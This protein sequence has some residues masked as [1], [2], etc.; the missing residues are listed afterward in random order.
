[1][2]RSCCHVANLLAFLVCLS[3]MEWLVRERDKRGTRPSRD[4]RAPGR[5]HPFH[6]PSIT[7]MPRLI[8]TIRLGLLIAVAALGGCASTQPTA[9]SGLASASQLRANPDDK[10]G[11]IPYSASTKTDWRP[12]T[13]AIV[14]PVQ[15]YAGADAQFDDV[16]D[17]DKAA[18]AKFMDEEFKRALARRFNVVDSPA[19]HTVLI[20][21]TLTGAKTNTALVSTVTRFDLLGGPYN[22]VQGLRGKEG[23]FM[24]SVSYAVEIYDASTLRLLDAYVTKQ[25]PNAM[26][27]SASIGKMAASKT[28]IEKG[29]TDLVERLN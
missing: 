18:L 9:Y 14:A 16:A 6:P 27:V 19:E 15:I 25:Y 20:K 22:I 1:M 23:I 10:S 5:R 8:L 28:G 24:G 11:H 13:R 21:A 3:V 12:Y 2:F 7:I 29:A 4:V 17:E 26:N